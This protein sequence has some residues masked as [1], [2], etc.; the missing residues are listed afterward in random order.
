MGQ[1]TYAGSAEGLTNLASAEYSV[2][3]VYWAQNEND[4][5]F[6]S[7]NIRGEQWLSK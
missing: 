3:S 4:P 2:S 1:T 6:V 5:Y 7:L